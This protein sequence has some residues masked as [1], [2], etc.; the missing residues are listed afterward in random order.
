MTLT[1]DFSKWNWWYKLIFRKA[2]IIKN[3]LFTCLPQVQHDFLNF[4][5]KLEIVIYSYKN[6]LKKLKLK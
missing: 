5:T 3:S 6:D 4:R 1:S 2:M